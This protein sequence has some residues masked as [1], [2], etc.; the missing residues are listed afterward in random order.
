MT[1]TVYCFIESLKLTDW[2][3]KTD[4]KGLFNQCLIKSDVTALCCMTGNALKIYNKNM[5]AH[6]RKKGT[7]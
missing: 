4:V 7:K 2:L 1:Y 5:F 3:K 6:I